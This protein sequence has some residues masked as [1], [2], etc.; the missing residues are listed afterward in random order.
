MVFV[1]LEGFLGQNRG[2]VSKRKKNHSQEYSREAG[3]IEIRLQEALPCQEEEPE[4]G[5]S[6]QWL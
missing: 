5:Q 2:G 4:V 6:L 1:F 3:G